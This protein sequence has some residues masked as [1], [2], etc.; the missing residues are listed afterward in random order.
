MKVLIAG[1]LL[2]VA[3]MAAPVSAQTA[4]PTWT[5]D[6]GPLLAKHCMNCH[7]P[8]E[9]APMSLLTYEAARR[10]RAPSATRCWPG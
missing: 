6:V 7:R 10:G 1:S 9:I 5:Q 3:A 2:L 8:G 4:A